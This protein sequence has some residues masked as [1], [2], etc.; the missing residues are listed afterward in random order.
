MYA[1]TQVDICSHKHTDIITYIGVFF[2]TFMHTVY[3]VNRNVFF[4]YLHAG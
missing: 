1:C 4:T 2:F 3:H